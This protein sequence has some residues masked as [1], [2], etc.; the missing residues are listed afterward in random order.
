MAKAVPGESMNM[1][2]RKKSET[3]AM[4][5]GKKYRCKRQ[6]QSV[7]NE[8]DPGKLADPER[9]VTSQEKP[10]GG[11]RLVRGP[12]IKMLG[13]CSIGH[14]FKHSPPKTFFCRSI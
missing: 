7:G 13:N 10:D 11:N 8:R 3:I 14:K 9:P 1:E 4:A 12:G 2:A 5:K 6:G